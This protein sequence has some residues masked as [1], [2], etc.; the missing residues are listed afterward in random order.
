MVPALRCSGS[1]RIRQPS[2]FD[3][4]DDQAELPS[5][6][7]VDGGN[8]FADQLNLRTEKL[9]GQCLDPTPIGFLKPIIWDDI[10][11]DAIQRDLSELALPDIRIPLDQ[12]VDVAQ[13]PAIGQKKTIGNLPRDSRVPSE[14][15]TTVALRGRIELGFIA[16]PVS[17]QG[18]CPVRETSDDDLARA[19]WENGLA[20]IIDELDDSAF[21]MFVV[22][23][24]LT[25]RDDRPHLTPGTVL[26][27]HPAHEALLDRRFLEG[28]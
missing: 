28:K 2:F 21:R 8:D 1:H 13:N 17:Q 18:H 23:A 10:H 16:G 22:L 24:R 26:V 5:V 9:H 3:L 11:G 19:P 12:R 7:A 14:G 27:R 25:H 20:I 6:R 4:R 15:A